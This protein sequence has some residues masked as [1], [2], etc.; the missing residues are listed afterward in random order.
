MVIP[1]LVVKRARAHGVPRLKSRRAQLAA[2]NPAMQ[3]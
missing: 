2:N 1:D 3:L